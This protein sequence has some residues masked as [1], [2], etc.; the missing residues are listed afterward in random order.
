LEF[1]CDL[2]KKYERRDPAEVLVGEL[3]KM[4]PLKRNRDFV[5]ETLSKE[6]D[7]RAHGIHYVPKEKED[8]AS[9]DYRNHLN[10]E[11]IPADIASAGYIWT[12]GTELFRKP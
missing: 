6:I 12:P 5:R 8:K 9:L 4:R 7:L 3:P 11:G 2:F 10:S 1:A